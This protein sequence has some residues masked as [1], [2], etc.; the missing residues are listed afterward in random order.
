MKTDN[1]GNNKRYLGL[2]LFRNFLRALE[3]VP[4]SAQT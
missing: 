3:I 1:K 4:V 2:R